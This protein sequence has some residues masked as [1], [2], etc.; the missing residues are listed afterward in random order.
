[1]FAKNRWSCSEDPE[2]KFEKKIIRAKNPP[3]E[4][5]TYSH[6]KLPNIH[7]NS[8]SILDTLDSVEDKKTMNWYKHSFDLQKGVS[9]S[10]DVYTNTGETQ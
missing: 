6:L 10:N 4:R 7:D 8:L 9:G 3:K 5:G 1:M 2:F